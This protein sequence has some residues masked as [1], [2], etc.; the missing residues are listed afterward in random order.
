MEISNS[1]QVEST[2]L[3]RNW[4]SKI[5]NPTSK[6]RNPNGKPKINTCDVKR[7][8]VLIT[9]IIA[10]TL[11]DVRVDSYFYESLYFFLFF[12]FVLLLLLL[13]FVPSYCVLDALFLNLFIT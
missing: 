6:M 9:K 12:Y 5:Q 11:C 10:S 1:I 8:E 2:Y 13:C 4:K 3:E 7:V